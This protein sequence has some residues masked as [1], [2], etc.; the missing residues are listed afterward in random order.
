MGPERM[1]LCQS[2][3]VSNEA[4]IETITAGYTFEAPTALRGCRAELVM[5]PLQSSQ[6][7]SLKPVSHGSK[8]ERDWTKGSS[9]VRL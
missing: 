8:T 5:A 4:L 6:K 9:F 7:R 3:G 2:R 1:G